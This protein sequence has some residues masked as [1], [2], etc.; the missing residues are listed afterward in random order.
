M[1]K[2][3]G[4]DENPVF[5]WWLLEGATSC[6]N[7][8]VGEG[9]NLKILPLPTITCANTAFQNATWKL[10]LGM[11]HHILSSLLTST[12]LDDRWTHR[13]SSLLITPVTTEALVYESLHSKKLGNLEKY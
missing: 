6:L 5:P 11:F 1:G 9:A 13:R 12:T 8:R 4:R 2:K 10:P 7:S 3:R